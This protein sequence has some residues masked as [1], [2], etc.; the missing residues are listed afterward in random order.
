[1]YKNTRG[2][3]SQTPLVLPCSR[4][5]PT[6]AHTRL[7]SDHGPLTQQRFRTGKLST[8]ATKPRG[9]QL[10]PTQHPPRTGKMCFPHWPRESRNDFVLSADLTDILHAHTRR[11]GTDRSQMTQLVIGTAR[12]QINTRNKLVPFFP[13]K[14]LTPPCHT[15]THT[16]IHFPLAGNLDNKAGWMS[17]LI[18]RDR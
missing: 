10:D 7:Y 6:T 4:N 11:G 15:H 2:Q 14:S 12:R 5:Q 9:Q 16:L 3:Q 1:M 18:N 17:T 8:S 13:S